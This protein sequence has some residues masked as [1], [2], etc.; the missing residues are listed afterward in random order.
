MNEIETLIIKIIKDY[1]EL[2]IGI[3]RK[4]F[5]QVKNNMDTIMKREEDLHDKM[6]DDDVWADL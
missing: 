3:D 6:A 4:D 2:L 1:A 5:D